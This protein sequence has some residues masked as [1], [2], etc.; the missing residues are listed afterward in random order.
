MA[1]LAAASRGR[2]ERTRYALRS[3]HL[4][5]EQSVSRVAEFQGS[6][7]RLSWFVDDHQLESEDVRWVLN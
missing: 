7:L 1:K 6:R 4:R 5:L 2:P 3:L